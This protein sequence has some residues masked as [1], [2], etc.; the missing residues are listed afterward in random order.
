M[1][2]GTMTNANIESAVTSSDGQE[3]VLKYKN[4]EK[5][6]V[7]PANVEVV[8]FDPAAVADLKPGEKIFVVAGK[9]PVF[10]ERFQNVVRRILDRFRDAGRLQRQPESQEVARIRK[11]DRVD[12]ITLARLHRD[13]MLALQPQQGLAHRL[14]ADGI[15]LGELLL[16]HIIARRQ[17]AGQNIRPQAFINI[18]TQKHHFSLDRSANLAVVKYHVK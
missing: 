5:K 8:M 2:N 15:A 18:V 3:L 9:A 7:V 17:A 12:A 6:F 11:R 16:A 10:V 13:E 14:A 4:G 1:P